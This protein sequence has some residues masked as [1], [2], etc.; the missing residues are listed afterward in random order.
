MKHLQPITRMPVK[1]STTGSVTSILTFLISMITAISP[2]LTAL[3]PLKAQ[4][5]KYNTT[6]DIPDFP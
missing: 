3:E 5:D 4:Q 6:T 2:F 1:G